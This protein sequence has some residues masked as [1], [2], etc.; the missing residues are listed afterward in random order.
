MKA[1]LNGLPN[2]IKTKVDKCSS[3]KGMW[4]KLQ[5]LHSKGEFTMFASQEDDRKQEGN[6]EPIKEVENKS[7]D[8]KAKEDLEDEE[9][10]DDFEEYLMAKLVAALEEISSL[11]KENED[12]KKQLDTDDHSLGK[13]RKEVDLFKLQVQK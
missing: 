9:N 10:K 6:P 12:L 8:I 1:I 7:E 3:T 2:A 5:D 4:D 11:K 13:T